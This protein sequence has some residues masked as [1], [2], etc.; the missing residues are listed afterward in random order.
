MAAG[1]AVLWSSDGGEPLPAST[2]TWILPRGADSQ[3]AEAWGGRMALELAA[4]ELRDGEAVTIVGD[5]LAVVR[6]CAGTGRLLRQ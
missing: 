5:N 3:V 1:A 4:D 6:Y 2:R